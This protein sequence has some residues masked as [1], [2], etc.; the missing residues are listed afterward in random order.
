MSEGGT[1]RRLTPELRAGLNAARALAAVYVVMHHVAQQNVHGALSIPFRFGQE[2]V[3]VFFLLSGFVIFA[4]ERDRVATEPGAYILRRF[5]RIY[6]P[7]LL[8]IALAALL[9]AIDPNYAGSFR[10]GDLV[11]TLLSVQD[12][13]ELKPGVI[14]DPVLNNNPLW[15]LSYEMV[16]YLTFPAVMVAWRRSARA[17]TTLVGLVALVGYASYLAAPNHWSLMAAYFLLWWA[18]AALAEAYLE[19]RYGYRALAPLLAWMTGLVLV[20]TVGV[21]LDGW[22]GVGFFPGLMVRHFVFALACVALV[23]TPLA[24]SA[25]ALALRVSAPTASLASISYGLYVFHYPLLLNWSSAHDPGGFLIALLLL[26]ILSWLGDRV[27][28]QILPRPRSRRACS[29]T[30]PR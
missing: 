3:I 14:A 22:R 11:A 26:V 10:P 2:A 29:V 24:K 17:A 23:L 27:L 30:V 9:Y 16:F 5:R 28:D 19:G 18:G 13:S 6:P 20:G 21:V 1:R 8:S 25:G 7:M 15:S 4:N 12:V